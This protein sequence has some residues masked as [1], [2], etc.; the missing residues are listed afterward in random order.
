MGL[1][2]GKTNL[3]VCK[4]DSSKWETQEELLAAASRRAAPPLN[5][6]ECF[7]EGIG[8]ASGKI[9]LSDEITPET[10]LI[11]GTILLNIRRTGHK[12]D[13]GLL[14]AEIQREEA[15]F[16]KANNQ[17]FVSRFAR[18]KIKQDVTDKLR[19]DAR[20]AVRG[21]EF[22]I[23]DD[24]VLIAANGEKDIDSVLM[25]LGKDLGLNARQAMAGTDVTHRR[26]FLTWLFAELQKE[27]FLTAVGWSM[28]GPLELVAKDRGEQEIRCT[29]ARIEGEL[30]TK[31]EEFDQ[32]L[33]GQKL[34]KKAKL[35]IV[36]EKRVWEFT[37]NADDW[38]FSGLELPQGDREEFAARIASM[39]ELHGELELLFNIWKQKYELS[40]GQQELPFNPKD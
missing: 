37:F 9:L 16:M 22:A 24:F 19:K 38:T 10:S 35:S 7:K 6:A 21:I 40:L 14:K 17:D 4:I 31:S 15:A 29:K 11:D 8:F 13:S 27:E 33:R 26:M 32:M 28:E 1:Q 25:L 34:L 12:I 39:Q 23:T 20:L 30:V 18:K 3:T 5:I 36:K 2:K